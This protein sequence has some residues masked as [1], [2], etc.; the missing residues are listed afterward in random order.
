MLNGSEN[1]VT[2]LLA[3]LFATEGVEMPH[4]EHEEPQ[5]HPEMAPSLAK[6]SSRGAEKSPE[7]RAAF[8]KAR[9][10]LNTPA[11]GDAFADL[12]DTTGADGQT[13]NVTIRKHLG[14]VAEHDRDDVAQDVAVKVMRHLSGEKK[15]DFDPEIAS[16]NGWLTTITRNTVLDI[17]EPG[18]GGRVTGGLGGGGADDGGSIDVARDR[19]NEPV[20]DPMAHMREFTP[21]EQTYC[22]FLKGYLTKVLDGSLAFPH[23]VKVRKSRDPEFRDAE[24]LPPEL[25]AKRV[26]ALNIAKVFAFMSHYGLGSAKL[27]FSELAATLADVYGIPKFTPHAGQQ[28]YETLWPVLEKEFVVAARSLGL[29]DS[30]VN[31]DESRR[32][33]KEKLDRIMVSFRGKLKTKIQSQSY[34]APFCEDVLADDFSDLLSV[35]ESWHA[36]ANR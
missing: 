22:A 16:F 17:L 11:F 10:A 8:A 28:W 26:T 35:L 5:R 34:G 3:H 24:A 29:D 9:A 13:P 36:T 25:K 33:V 21:D 20:H 14:K 4:P 23:E 27:K 30:V 18:A 6:M 12:M 19:R 15:G 2:G 1:A 31:S 32:K 7:V